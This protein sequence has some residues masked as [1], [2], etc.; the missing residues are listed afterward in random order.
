M[1]GLVITLVY[2]CTLLMIWAPSSSSSTPLCSLASTQRILLHQCFVSYT[3]DTYMF[4]E[5]AGILPSFHSCL[6]VSSWPQ[7]L[8]VGNIELGGSS[9][10]KLCTHHCFQ[11]PFRASQRSVLGLTVLW[12][13]VS[14]GT[15]PDTPCSLCCLAGNKFCPVSHTLNVDALT[16]RCEC[17]WWVSS[18]QEWRGKAVIGTCPSSPRRGLW[19]PLPQQSF[20]SSVK[21]GSRAT[22]GLLKL[23]IFSGLWVEFFEIVIQER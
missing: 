3:Y 18:Q 11:S 23:F 9:A 15:Q 21:E 14:I 19:Y 7:Y 8:Y 12:P 13:Q 22:K 5:A 4:E 17:F 16:F 20:N 1:K 6:F 10:C 2:S